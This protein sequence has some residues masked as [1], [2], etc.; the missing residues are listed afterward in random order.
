MGHPVFSHVEIIII[1]IK[2]IYSFCLLFNINRRKNNK[3]LKNKQYI[4][5]KWLIYIIQSFTNNIITIKKN[6]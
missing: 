5:Y 4:T 6:K 1:I 2:N 3:I